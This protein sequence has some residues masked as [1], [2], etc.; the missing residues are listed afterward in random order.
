MIRT[1]YI[2]GPAGSDTPVKIG[3]SDDVTKRLSSLQIGSPVELVLHHALHYPAAFAQRIE[4]AA[5]KALEQYH[6]RGEWHD[7]PAGEAKLVVERVADELMRNQ[8]PFFSRGDLFTRIGE[9]H[10]LNPWAA[11]AVGEYRQI[12]A[13]RER[14]PELERMNAL[15]IE[16]VGINGLIAFKAMLT[17]AWSMDTALWCQQR[18][19]RAARKSIAQVINVLSDDYARRKE[20]DLLAAIEA[21]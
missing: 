7:V 10:P 3:V 11:E 5:H 21:A 1:V 8:E 20:D 9:A 13:S 12:R 14:L 18:A 16:K 4:S 2:I 19:H 6:R 15:V 17:S